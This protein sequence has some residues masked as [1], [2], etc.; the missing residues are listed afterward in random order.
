MNSSVLTDAVYKK[1]SNA[2][3]KYVERELAKEEGSRRFTLNQIK[4]ETFHAESDDVDR[5]LLRGL[6]KVL[7]ITSAS[8]SHC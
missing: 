5:C 3:F 6:R 1:L 2:E 8:A 7:A 4:D